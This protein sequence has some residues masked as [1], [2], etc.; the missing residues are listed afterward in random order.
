MEK[1]TA[2][3]FPLRNPIHPSEADPGLIGGMPLKHIIESQQFT[4]PL[5]MDL[6]ERS[7]GMGRVVARGGTLD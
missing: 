5:L 6:F 3:P 7:R 2:I 4:V 1:P